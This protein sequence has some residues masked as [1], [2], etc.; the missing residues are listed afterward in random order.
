MKKFNLFQNLGFK[1]VIEALLLV[2]FLSSLSF[3]ALAGGWEHDSKGW[4][5]SYSISYEPLPYY[6]KDDITSID[7]DRYAFDKDGYMVIGWWRSS[8]YENIED[9]D[10]YEDDN[11]YKDDNYWYYFNEDGKMRYEPL[12]NEGKT[13]YFNQSTGR[14][15]NPTGEAISQYEVA[16]KGINVDISGLITSIDKYQEI[17]I[18]SIKAHIS[19]VER[20]VNA[21]NNLPTDVPNKYKVQHAYMLAYVRELSPRA[22][23]LK[24]ILANIEAP[25]TDY[26]KLIKQIEEFNGEKINIY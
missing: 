3:T 23:I 21:I 5:Y 2:V 9:D 26:Q 14:C 22:E 13:Y 15:L 8:L 10:Y 19:A 24:Q 12:N 1:L 11:Y 7:G 6:V 20:L 25:N 16:I 17:D 18:E 4:K